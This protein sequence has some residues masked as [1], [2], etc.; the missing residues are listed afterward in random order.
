M[1]VIFVFLLSAIVLF[2]LYQRKRGIKELGMYQNL[3]LLSGVQ[4]K[5][6]LG[7]GS[8]GEVFLG[9]WNGNNLL[10]SQ[11]LGTK[12][13][14]KLLKDKSQFG[15]FMKEIGTLGFVPTV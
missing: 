2:I 4:I 14:M 1:G 11:I 3:P 13:A 9:D 6:K 10:I 12:V 5:K 8:F 15:E 7:A